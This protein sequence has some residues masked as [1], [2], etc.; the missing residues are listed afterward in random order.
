M[1]YK[2]IL[3]AVDLSETSEAVI[4]KAVSL[5]KNFNA[6]LSLIYVDIDYAAHY[7][8]LTYAEFNK[9]ETC[10]PTSDSVHKELQMLADKTEYPIANCLCVTGDLNKKLNETLKNLNADLLVCGHHHDFWSRLLSS[11]RKLLNTTVTDLLVIQL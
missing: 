7:T 4:A 10:G 5:A 2:H 9:L 6:T 1:S 11:V 8:G 3:V